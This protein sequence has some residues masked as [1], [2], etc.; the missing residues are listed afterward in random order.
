[1]QGFLLVWSIILSRGVQVQNCCCMCGSSEKAIYHVFF[2]CR[3]SKKVWQLFNLEVFNFIENLRSYN[4]GLDTMIHWLKDNDFVDERLY[5]MWL[6][7]NNK[8]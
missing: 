2:D 3:Y 1:M 4:D 8:N 6:I 5:V 7:W